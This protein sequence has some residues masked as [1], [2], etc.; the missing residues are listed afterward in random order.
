MGSGDWNDGM[1]RVGIEGRGESVWLTWFLIDVLHQFTEIADRRGDHDQAQHYRDRAAAYQTAVEEHAWD[2]AWYLRAF[3]DDGTPLGS[4]KNRECQ[5]DSIAQSWAVLSGA[6]D[7]DRAEQSMEAVL[8]RLVRPDDGLML[9]FT[10]PF[11]K[12][13]RDPGY[14][15]GY[16]PGIRENGG[17]YT[18]AAIW[19]A[20]AFSRLG[21]GDLAVG[22]FAMLNP[23]NHARFSEDV[24]KYKVEPYDIA[25]DI[26]S[27]YPHIGRGGWTWYTGSASWLYRLGIESI[28]GLK[29]EGGHIVIDPCIPEG[30][31]QYELTYRTCGSEY[32][33]RVENPKRVSRG[34]KKVFLDSTEIDGG[35]IPLKENGGIHK[36]RVILGE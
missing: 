19:T 12:T 6:G 31:K 21:R 22:L 14:I 3:F 33:I 10:P 9:L 7:P 27:V 13:P 30:W 26:Y 5:I 23:I 4:S 24:M 29:L 1:N 28:L 32:R 17:Q 8:Q 11:N 25:A 15:K 34:V 2:G 16:L 20:W 35:R 18:H 36:V